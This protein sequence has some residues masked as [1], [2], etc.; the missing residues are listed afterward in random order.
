VGDR[1]VVGACSLVRRDVPADTIV[2]G[3]PAQPIGR[4]PPPTG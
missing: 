4:R 2:A 3:N 1:A